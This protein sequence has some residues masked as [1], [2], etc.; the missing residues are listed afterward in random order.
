LFSL[1]PPKN[2]RTRPVTKLC[3]ALEA[4]RRTTEGRARDAKAF[5]GHFFPQKDATDRLFVHL[6]NE[7]RADLLSNW[8]IRGKKSALRDDDEKVRVTIVDALEAGD[9]DAS[10]VEQG[11]TP[12]IL[13]DWVPLDDWWAFWRGAA[14]PLASVHKA[15]ATARELA[16]FDDR[17]FLTNLK[18]PTHKLEGTDVVCA[19]LPKEQL[20]AW[21]NAIHASG[22]ATPAGLVRALGW[23]TILA[24]TAPEALTFALDALARDIGLAPRERAAPA[25]A[26]AETSKAPVTSKTASGGYPKV[27]LAKIELQKGPS[28]TLRGASPAL[29]SAATTESGQFSAV[30]AP[31]AGALPPRT[32]GY[33]QQLPSVIISDAA[34]ESDVDGSVPPAPPSSSP[35]TARAL[36]GAPVNAKEQLPPMRPPAAT[37][38]G[39]G[40]PTPF[41]EP[42]IAVDITLPPGPPT[43]AT[44]DEPAW[45]PPRAEPGDMGWDLVHGV[46]YSMSPNNIQPKYNFEQ[47]DEPTSEIDLPGIPR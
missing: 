6:P 27:D 44:A 4:F 40:G 35:P 22:D 7:V 47:D 25:S 8:G 14:L 9:I 12:D 32:A 39:V 33:A 23:E 5:L 3:L 15:L 37:L 30:R 24:K 11:V 20:V 38:T 2:A 46:T 31:T 42:P 34:R 21:M 16:L 19:A 1:V 43:E 28:T 45:A 41:D 18:L 26:S 10:I 36:F 17:W 29:P 13:V